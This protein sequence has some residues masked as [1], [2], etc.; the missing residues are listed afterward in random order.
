MNEA[1]TYPL[2][3]DVTTHGVRVG[4]NAFYLPDES[5]P[6]DDEYVF[7]YRIVIL[8]DSERTVTLLSRHWDLID[9]EGQ[10]REVDGEGVVGQKPRLAPGEAFKY[11]SFAVLPTPWGT[12]EGHYDFRAEDNQAQLEVAIGR[13]YLTQQSVHHTVSHEAEG[14]ETDITEAGPD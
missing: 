14:Q 7:G 10:L 2:M 6:E 5:T 12:M 1:T 8:N 4:A 13:F 11:H 3:S 9:G